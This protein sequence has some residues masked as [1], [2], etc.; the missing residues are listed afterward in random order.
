V[1]E[2]TRGVVAQRQLVEPLDQLTRLQNDS[3]GYARRQA[4][5]ALTQTLDDLREENPL[6]KAINGERTPIEHAVVEQRHDLRPIELERQQRLEPQRIGARSSP[7]V[8]TGV[9]QEHRPRR[10]RRVSLLTEPGSPRAVRI[11]LTQ[12][13]VD[14]R[15]F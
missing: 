12:S 2:A 10:P 8:F 9:L 14:E 5:P 3:D 6:L 11:E 4:P 15:P 13:S 1:N 7:V